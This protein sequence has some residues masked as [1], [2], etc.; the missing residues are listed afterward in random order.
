[1]VCKTT[2]DILRERMGFIDE[3][4]ERLKAGFGAEY[5]R[6]RERA[7]DSVQVMSVCIIDGTF[8]EHMG[9][10]LLGVTTWA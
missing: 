1:M 9:A 10:C 5:D 8:G 2:W 7:R 4:C 6:Y 3:F